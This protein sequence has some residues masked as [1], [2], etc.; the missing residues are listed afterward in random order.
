MVAA[1]PG[2]IRLKLQ[3]TLAQWR[4]WSCQPALCAAPSVVAV[5]TAGLSNFSVLVEGGQ[6]FVVRIDGINPAAHNLNR[7]GEWRSL[8]T[9]ARA[10]LAPT[11]R[12]FNPELGSLVCDYLEPDKQ[13]P[14]DMREIATLLRAIHQLPARHQRLDLPERLLSY[15]KQLAHRAPAR[16]GKLAPHR[17]AVMDLLSRCENQQQPLV[18]CHHDLLRANRLYSAGQLF[19]LDW[20]YSA[21]GNPWYDLAVVSTGDAL[22]EK[23]VEALLAA[24]LAQPASA[25]EHQLVA[26]Y[27]SVYRYLELLWY[28]AQKHPGLSATALQLKLDLLQKSLAQGA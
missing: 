3:Q 2:N 10:G 7:Q 6:R 15:E 9:A 16:A 24:Y 12:Y 28:L 23:N 19:A 1:L 27:S 14:L 20:E 8:E 21:M 11:P 4:Q 13:Q 18:L 22:A 26:D 25:A 17:A 5:L